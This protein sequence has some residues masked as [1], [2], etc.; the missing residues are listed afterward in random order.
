MVLNSITGLSGED[1]FGLTVRSKDH[2]VPCTGLEWPKVNVQGKNIRIVCSAH[3]VFTQVCSEF[4]LCFP[5]F[6]KSA[7]QLFPESEMISLIVQ[8][9]FSFQNLLIQ[10]I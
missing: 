7:G 3:C 2:L 10:C 6:Q 8:V 5:G 1:R 9:D 4:L